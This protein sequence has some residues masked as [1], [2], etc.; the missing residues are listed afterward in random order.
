[1]K[2]EVIFSPKS[3]ASANSSPFKFEEETRSTV[4]GS[5]SQREWSTFSTEFVRMEGYLEKKQNKWPNLY[6]KR[7]FKLTPNGERLLYFNEEPVSVGHIR[8][9]ERD[10]VLLLI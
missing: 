10:Q 5:F 1:M 2:D 3:L 9:K 4:S 8:K 7:Y 6:N